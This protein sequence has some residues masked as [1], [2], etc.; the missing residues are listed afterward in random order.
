MAY[1]NNDTLIT[2][3][4]TVNA[5]TTNNMKMKEKNKNNGSTFPVPSKEVGLRI[6]TRL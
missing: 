1:Y 6:P 3:T 2:A 4:T 5:T